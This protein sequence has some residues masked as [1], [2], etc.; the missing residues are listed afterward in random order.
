M[1][2]NVERSDG[3]KIFDSRCGYGTQSRMQE[4]TARVMK[5]ETLPIVLIDSNKRRAPATSQLSS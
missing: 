3:Q 5:N 2:F 4:H 1:W